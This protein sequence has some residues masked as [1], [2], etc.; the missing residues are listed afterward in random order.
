[1][2]NR[3][4]VNI[5]TDGACIGNP[6]PGGYGAV[7]VCGDAHRELSGG[8]RLTTNNRMELMAAIEALKA[9]KQPCSVAIHCDATYVVEGV[10]NGQM[11]RWRA[12]G[13]YRGDKVAAANADLWEQLLKLCETHEVIFNWVKSHSGDPDNELCD[14]L[15]KRAARGSDLLTD[16]GYEMPSFPPPRPTLFDGLPD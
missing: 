13:W 10:M 14:R 3:K 16:A 7:L 5:W 4:I 9:L 6:G 11:R 1:M 8:Y 15:A 2:S 12:V